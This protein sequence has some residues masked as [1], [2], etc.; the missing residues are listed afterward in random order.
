MNRSEKF[1]SNPQEFQ[2]DRFLEVDNVKLSNIPGFYA[3]GYG[4]RPCIGYQLGKA[5]L[6]S[7]LGNIVNK[8][9]VLLPDEDESDM[10]GN[11]DLVL[12]PPLF[13]LKF[14]KRH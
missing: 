14:Q 3:F 7:F 9:Q 10:Q 4:R 11:A 2:P 12:E 6:F 8:F 13:K 1:W 5:C